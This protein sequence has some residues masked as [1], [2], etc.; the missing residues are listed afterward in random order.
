LIGSLEVR[1]PTYI[2]VAAGIKGHGRRRLL[3]FAYLLVIT[4][5]DKFVYFV[6]EG[7]LY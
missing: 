3:L 4:L 2:W 1:R 5:T 6:A 7:F